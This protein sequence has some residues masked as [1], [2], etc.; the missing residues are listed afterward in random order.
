MCI[1]ATKYSIYMHLMMM[2]MMIKAH[3]N[4]DDGPDFFFCFSNQFFFVCL[5]T[6]GPFSRE[7]L[8]SFFLFCFVT[9]NMERERD[10]V[11]HEK[12]KRNCQYIN[13]LVTWLVH[14]GKQYSIIIII[15]M[16]FVTISTITIVGF[17]SF[18]LAA[19]CCCLITTVFSNIFCWWELTNKQTKKQELSVWFIY[20]YIVF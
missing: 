10:G 14:F 8:I 18:S 19:F 1:H 20:K 3:K 7:S 9:I 15:I 6:F 4:N 13:V 11:I 16:R 17:Q 12:W 5:E 2:M